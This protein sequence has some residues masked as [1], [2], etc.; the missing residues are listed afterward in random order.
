MIDGSEPGSW[1]SDPWPKPTPRQ[2]QALAGSTGRPLVVV[3]H[4]VIRQNYAHVQAAPAAGAG[5]L[6]RQ[7]QPGAGDRPHALP[8]RRQLRRGVVARVHAGLRAHHGAA[9]EGAAGFHLGQDRLREPDQ[10]EGDARGARPST[11]RS[12]PSTT[13]PRSRRSEAVRA[14][15][16]PASLRIRVPN[17]GSM[18]ELS[19]KF[20]CDPGEAVALIEEAHSGG[21]GRGG[22]SASTSAAS[23]RTSRTSCRR[24]TWRRR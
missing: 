6:R 21:P 9:G 8:R 2:L 12:S 14:A 19:S 16:R 13:R 1:L 24:S 17:T 4:D 22:R 7:G 11:S 3:D 23:A 20:G 18:V 15:R 10:A 5:V